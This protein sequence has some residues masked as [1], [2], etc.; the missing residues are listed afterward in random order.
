MKTLAEL[1]SLRFGDM[2]SAA[3]PAACADNALLRGLA[4]RGV[5]RRF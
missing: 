5:V 4:G 3:I 2:D 1:L